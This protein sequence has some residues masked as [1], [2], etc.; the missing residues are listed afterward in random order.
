MPYLEDISFEQLAR[1]L[2]DEEDML[3]GF[4]RD[5]REM[6]TEVRSD[7]SKTPDI[8]NDIIRPA[9]DKVERR[10]KSIAAI[11]GLKVAGV[12]VGAATL[13]LVALTTAGIGASI[14]SVLGASGVGIIA[15]EVGDYLKEKADVREM[16]YYLLWRLGR[17]SKR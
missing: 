7:P 14:A 2:E 9:T 10:F 16:P 3:A 12:T 4:R 15:K 13:S 1:V 17:E 8:L 6:L 5:V 11:H